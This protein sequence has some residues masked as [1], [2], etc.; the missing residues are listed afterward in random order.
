MDAQPGRQADDATIA[1][2]DRLKAVRKSSEGRPED[3]VQEALRQA[4]RAELSGVPDAEAGT[5]LDAARAL[6]VGEARGRER[7]VEDLEAEVRR[8]AGEL[9]ALRGGDKGKAPRGAA[10]SSDSTATLDT[11]RDGLLRITGGQDVTPDSLGLPPSEARVFRLIRELL[12]FARNFE[13]GVHGLLMAIEI[14][15]G[16]DSRMGQRQQ[17]IIEDRF[18]ACLQDE[19]GSVEALKEALARNNRFVLQLNDAYET[20]I[21]Q[22]THALIDELDPQPIIDSCQSRLGGLNFEKAWK[23]FA[24][25]YSDLSSLPPEDTWARFFQDPFKEKLGDFVDPGGAKD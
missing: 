21:R 17:K 13:T 24:S 5:R 4:L 14:G 25:K 8:L 3:E 9:E 20:A 18:R 1:L 7:R 19:E 12:L 23:A 2:V 22:G 11:I 16:L 15:P 6:L 10:A